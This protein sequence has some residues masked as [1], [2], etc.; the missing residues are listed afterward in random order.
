MPKDD[1]IFENYKDLYELTKKTV[2]D[3]IEFYKTKNLYQ[4]V[5]Y[6]KSGGNYPYSLRILIKETGQ[7]TGII[8][9]RIFMHL[10]STNLKQDF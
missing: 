1:D 5:I 3:H 4:K 2:D 7:K 6:L 10:K 9:T 8:G